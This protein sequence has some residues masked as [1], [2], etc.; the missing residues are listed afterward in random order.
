MAT[1]RELK[2]AVFYAST[3]P[4]LLANI[5]AEVIEIED[6]PEPVEPVN[7]NT[8]NKEPDNGDEPNNGAE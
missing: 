3:K 4:E 8:D 5:L 2:K 1:M 7:P 6:E